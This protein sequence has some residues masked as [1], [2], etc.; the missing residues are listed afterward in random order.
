MKKIALIR[1]FIMEITFDFNK[2]LQTCAFLLEKAGGENP[3]NY[4]IKALVY[5]R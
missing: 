3:E 4:V 5:R 2:T 1:F